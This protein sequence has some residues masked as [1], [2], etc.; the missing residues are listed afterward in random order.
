MQF[1]VYAK[2]YVTKSFWFDKN[3]F[4]TDKEKGSTRSIFTASNVKKVVTVCIKC[5]KDA[6]IIAG[7]LEIGYKLTHEGMDDVSSVWQEWLNKTFLDDKIKIWIESKNIIAMGNPYD[8]ISDKIMKS[9]P[10]EK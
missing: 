8:F 2:K 3:I 5:A 4:N 6:I 7:W 9:F 10:K 1:A